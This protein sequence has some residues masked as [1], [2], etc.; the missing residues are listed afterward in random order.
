MKRQLMLALLVLPLLSALGGCIVYDDG[1]YH[2]GHEGRD[3]DWHDHD[4]RDHDRR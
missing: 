3:R 2:R 1:F 4:F